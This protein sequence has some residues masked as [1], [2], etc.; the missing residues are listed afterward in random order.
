MPTEV[1]ERTGT[2]TT[3]I[4]GPTG[5]TLVLK[6]ECEPLAV[7]FRHT[8][9]MGASTDWPD[10]SPHI[11]VMQSDSLPGRNEIMPYDGEIVLGRERFGPCKRKGVEIPNSL[12]VHRPVMNTNEIAAWYHAQ[13]VVGDMSR[14]YHVTVVYSKRAFVDVIT[15][16]E[17]VLIVR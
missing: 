3:E 2:R 5:D 9:D 13:G 8:L 1:V 10:Y 4:F 6:F 15:P 11:S 12:Y 7:R 16:D 14:E 17:R